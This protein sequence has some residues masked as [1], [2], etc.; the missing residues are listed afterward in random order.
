MKVVESNFIVFNEVKNLVGV[1]KIFM[2]KV[3]CFVQTSGCS[4]LLANK[5]KN[6]FYSFTLTSPCYFEHIRLKISYL[7][8]EDYSVSIQYK[9]KKIVFLIFSLV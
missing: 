4:I 7:F 1:K 8:T 2:I 6:S 9:K 5:P 3:L